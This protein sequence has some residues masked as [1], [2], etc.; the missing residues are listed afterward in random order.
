MKKCRKIWLL[1]K[2]QTPASKEFKHLKN[3]EN[4]NY[5]NYA[6]MNISLSLFCNLYNRDN[7]KN[8]KS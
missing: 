1:Q 7:Q 6:K 5:Y 4:K 8:P 3:F 2:L